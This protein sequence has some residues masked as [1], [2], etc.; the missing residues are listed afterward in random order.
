MCGVLTV[1]LVASHEPTHLF[2]EAD[3]D[4]DDVVIRLRSPDMP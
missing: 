2:V 3:L 4:F 1:R